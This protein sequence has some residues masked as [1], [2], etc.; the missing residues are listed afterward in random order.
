MN[1]VFLQ[2]GPVE[3]PSGA[4]IS[5]A[6]GPA[7]SANLGLAFADVARARA[8]HPALETKKDAY[9]YDWVLRAA[10]RVCRYLCA[11][12]GYVAGAHVALQLSNSPEYLAAFYGTLLADCVAVP[13]PVSLERLRRQKIHDLCQFD[14]LFTRREDNVVRENVSAV[15]TLNLSETAGEDNPRPTPRRQGSDL[16]MVLF[17]S[18]STG[19]PKGV[20][21][22]HRNLLA[23]A[24]SILRVLPMGAD[25][26][27][28]MIVPF[29]HAL[30]NSVLQTHILAGATLLLDRASA[31]PA[32]IV[33][34]LSQMKAT[35]FTAT[36]EVYG[37]LLKFGRLEN[38]GSRA[39]VTWR[40]PAANYA[41]P[42]RQKSRSAL[43]RP[44]FI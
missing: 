22:S 6:V 41:M 4:A 40:W 27:A 3:A 21:L 2:I 32:A 18:G 30:G 15:P 17:T 8:A 1:T 23:N 34:A 42:W 9:S 44:R 26:R 19:E 10:E 7:S 12:P 38:D 24:N 37:M 31:F 36:P 39:C 25:D 11:R 35:S 28:F 29:C 5:S 33:D 13:L 14:V 20:M 16:A 43:R